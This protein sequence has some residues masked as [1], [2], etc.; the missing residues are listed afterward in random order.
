MHSGTTVSAIEHAST[1]LGRL[2]DAVDVHAAAFAATRGVEPLHQIR[3]S[4]RRLRAA[5]AFVEP[6]RHGDEGLAHAGRRVRTLARPFGRLRD[7]D[8]LLERLAVGVSLVDASDAARLSGVLRARRE[9]LAD[10]AVQ[11]V[12]SARWARA[13]AAV[14]DVGPWRTSPLADLAADRFAGARLDLWWWAFLAGSEGLA[15][16]APGRRHRVRIEAKR[17][18][19]ASEFSAGLFPEERRAPFVEGMKTIQDRLGELQDSVVAQDI[20]RTAGFAPLPCAA[21]DVVQRA[22]AARAELIARGPFWEPI[23]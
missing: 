5:L 4:A 11:V 3:V 17:L 14:H 20:I 7:L 15:D 9:R 8:V 18:R 6:L 13:L 19:Y 12:T 2:L 22:H 23:R 21:T 16:M 1:V 10:E